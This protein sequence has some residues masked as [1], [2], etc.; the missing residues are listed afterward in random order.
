[1]PDCC[2]QSR[3]RRPSTSNTKV[4]VARIP[5][6]PSPRLP[7]FPSSAFPPSSHLILQPR[8][9][10]T[11]GR[12]DRRRRRRRRA[13][14]QEQSQ[15]PRKGNEGWD[16]RRTEDRTGTAAAATKRRFVRGEGESGRGASRGGREGGRGE[17]ARVWLATR[18]TTSKEKA[19]RRLLLRPRPPR[20]PPLPL[21]AV[22]GRPPFLH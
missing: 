17:E 12:G 4:R 9:H 2:W 11:H 13:S 21:R 3:R 16:E 5:F 10:S 19:R 8:V 18:S 20:H 7:C 15:Q 14:G 22:S 6:F 1:M